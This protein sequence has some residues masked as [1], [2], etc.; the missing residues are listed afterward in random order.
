MATAGPLRWNSLDGLISWLDSK[1]E[2][3]LGEYSEAYNALRKFHKEGDLDDQM[4]VQASSLIDELAFERVA[5]LRIDGDLKGV[6]EFFEHTYD[7]TLKNR[8]LTA[9]SD[10]ADP[11]FSARVVHHALGRKNWNHPRASIT[12]VTLRRNL[13]QELIGQS[14]NLADVGWT[15]GITGQNAIKRELEQRWPSIL[16]DFTND[17]SK[18]TLPFSHEKNSGK[19]RKFE[20]GSENAPLISGRS[21]SRPIVLGILIIVIATLTLIG[22]KWCRGA[23]R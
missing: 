11:E 12:N 16:S 17:K 2:L 14:P 23:G 7:S 8:I 1:Q 5:E 15:D 18:S 10:G 22:I 19:L 6:S 3:E 9:L 21:G 20:A 13:I 4:E